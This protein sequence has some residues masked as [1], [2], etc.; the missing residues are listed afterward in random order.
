MLPVAF[1]CHPED[2]VKVLESWDKPVH[3]HICGKTN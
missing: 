1:E 3:C 2:P